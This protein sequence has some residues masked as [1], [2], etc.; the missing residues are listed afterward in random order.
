MELHVCLYQY[1]VIYVTDYL[2]LVNPEDYTYNSN[3]ATVPAGEM[4]AC[5]EVDLQDSPNLEMPQSFFVSI[6]LDDDT[7][8]RITLATVTSGE[9]EI[10]DDDSM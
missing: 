7:D 6:E 2:I 3:T 10:D 8:S 9:I 4:E 5:V 1:K